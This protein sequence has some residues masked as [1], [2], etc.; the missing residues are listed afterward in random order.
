MRVITEN[1]IIIVYILLKF[2]CTLVSNGT[3]YKLQRFQKLK[4]KYNSAVN[5]SLIS[6]TYKNLGIVYLYS[7]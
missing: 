7:L 4:R 3:L 1:I 5:N 2:I 6:L